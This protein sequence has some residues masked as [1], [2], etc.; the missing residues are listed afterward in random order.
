MRTA[1]HGEMGLSHNGMRQKMFEAYEESIRVPLVIS[2]PILFP[3]AKT[4]D[5][6]VSTVDLLPTLAALAKVPQP[7]AYHLSGTDLSPILSQPDSTHT[8]KDI[9]YTFD[10]EQ[11][12][13]KNGLPFWPGRD[14]VIEQPNH[15]RS[16]RHKDSGGV[17]KF[18]RYFDPGAAKPDQLEMYHLYNADGS[19]A[20]TLE[21]FNLANSAVVGYDPEKVSELASALARVEMMRLGPKRTTFLPMITR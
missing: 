18:S 15:I 1:D 8:F 2:N 21:K 14:V 16:I 10:D 9:L 12:G 19:P 5:S 3:T 7:E 13:L 6:W 4:N 17:W 11:A 20:D